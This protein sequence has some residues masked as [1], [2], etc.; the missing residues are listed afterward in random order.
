[1]IIMAIIIIVV[2]IMKIITIL[3]TLVIIVIRILSNHT[4]NP[5]SCKTAG[6]GQRRKGSSPF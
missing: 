5:E 6:F 3:E 2:V 4:R 1:M